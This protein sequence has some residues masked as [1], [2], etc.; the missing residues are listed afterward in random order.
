VEVARWLDPVTKLLARRRGEHTRGA[1]LATVV[2]S[3][4]PAIARD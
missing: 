3:H 2:A 4:H 1:V